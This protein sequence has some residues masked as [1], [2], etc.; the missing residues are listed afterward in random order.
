MSLPGSPKTWR[1]TY[2]PGAS[3]PA[4]QK[5]MG[6]RWQ[7]NFMSWV[8]ITQ[9]SKVIVHMPTGQD[10]YASFDHTATCFVTHTCDYYLTRGGAATKQIIHDRNTGSTGLY[11]LQG[12]IWS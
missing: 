5:P 2:N 12:G 6:D 10:V 8:T 7:H 1:V 4:Y 3:P 11:F 9:A